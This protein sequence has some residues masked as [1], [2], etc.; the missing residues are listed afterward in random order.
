VMIE[1]GTQ[2]ISTHNGTT[3]TVTVGVTSNVTRD[4]RGILRLDLPNGWKS[5]PAQLPVEFSKRGEKQE[6]HFKVVPA[7]LQQGR[8]TVRA[9]LEYEGETYRE[10]YTLV[11]REDL[12]SFYYYQPAR[13]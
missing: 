6:F 13:Q 7:D 1:P 5:Q 4:S 2:V 12:G 8:A 11:T 9:I 10:G 3:T